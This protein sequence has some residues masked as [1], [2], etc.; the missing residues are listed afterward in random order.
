MVTNSLNQLNNIMKCILK[1]ALF[2]TLIAGFTLAVRAEDSAADLVSQAQELLAAKDS[3][4]AIKLYEQAIKADP[5]NAKLQT[6][7]A[8]ALGVRINEVNFMVKGMIA[9]KMLKAYQ[10]SV[11]IDPDHVTGWIGLSRYY[12]NAPPIAGGSLDKATGYANEVKKRVAWLGE[13]ELGL[14]AE[15][16]DDKEAAADHFRAALDGNPE[17]GEAIAALKRVTAAE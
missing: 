12:H 10:A 4:G 17:H 1:F 13:V 6:D 9:G 8:N 11:E 3:K 5:A 16:R 15:K 7:Y 2:L 14:I